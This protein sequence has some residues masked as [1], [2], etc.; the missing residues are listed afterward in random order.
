M[1]PALSQN[2]CSDFQPCLTVISPWLP[3]THV[4][5]TPSQ[6]CAALVPPPPPRRFYFP[7]FQGTWL[8]LST[9]P[10]PSGSPLFK[11]LT[12]EFQPLTGEFP[13]LY[14]KA[15][16]VPPGASMVPVKACHESQIP[17]DKPS[18]WVTFTFRSPGTSTTQNP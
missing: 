17:A 18:C 10:F 13:I 15:P 14:F 7:R 2:F 6:F 11:E 4:S 1:L 12:V 3:P 5:T 16:L 9:H 8:Q